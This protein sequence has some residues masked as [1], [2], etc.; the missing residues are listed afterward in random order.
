MPVQ[1]VLRL[2]HSNG[3]G[4][5]GAFDLERRVKEGLSWA[6]R[7]VC[8]SPETSG[9]ELRLQESRICVNGSSLVQVRRSHV[10]FSSL[11]WK[12]ITALK[13]ELS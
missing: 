2:V 12:P 3:K 1:R 11:F 10:R 7:I 5:L 13:R 6:E 9:V 4:S 8:G